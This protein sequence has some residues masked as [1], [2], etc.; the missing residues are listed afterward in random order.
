MRPPATGSSGAGGA[1]RC[2]SASG[3]TRCFAG[4]GSRFPRN[5]SKASQ[6]T[7]FCFLFCFVFCFSAELN[8][9]GLNFVLFGW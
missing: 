4:R 6:F 3:A 1:P 7:H 8:W 9:I 2:S 5:S